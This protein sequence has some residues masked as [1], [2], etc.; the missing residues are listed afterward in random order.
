MTFNNTINFSVLKK[1]EWYTL[2]LINPEVKCRVFNIP[3]DD[4]SFE[5]YLQYE[6]YL[7]ELGKDRVFKISLPYGPLKTYM[8]MLPQNLKQLN[9]KDVEF[10]IMKLD[11]GRMKIKNWRVLKENY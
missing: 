11:Q 3:Q 7:T 9:G 6:G 4:G 8:D 1:N 5:K 10:M 2:T